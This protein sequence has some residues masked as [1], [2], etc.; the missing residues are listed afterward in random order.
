M[1][2]LMQATPQNVG[3]QAASC[4]E[5]VKLHVLEWTKHGIGPTL[6]LDLPKTAMH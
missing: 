3:H 1:S 2:G 6:G 4:E 5:P